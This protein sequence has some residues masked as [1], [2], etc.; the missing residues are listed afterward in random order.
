MLDREQING[1]QATVSCLLCAVAG[2]V[3]PK[4]IFTGVVAVGAYDKG[5]YVL[6]YYWE[7]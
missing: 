3:T 7:R 6:S 5:R 1:S 4:N 2:Y